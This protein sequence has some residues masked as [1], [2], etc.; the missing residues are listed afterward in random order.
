MLNVVQECSSAKQVLSVH[1]MPLDDCSLLTST[2]Y[3]RSLNTKGPRL[4]DKFSQ[5]T[6]LFTVLPV[7]AARTPSRAPQGSS[8]SKAS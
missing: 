5:N 1:A 8:L 6:M 2:T 3:R 7:S 4:I